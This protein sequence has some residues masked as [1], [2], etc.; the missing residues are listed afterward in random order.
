MHFPGKF[1]HY[2]NII[3]QFMIAFKAVIFFMLQFV[4][5]CLVCYNRNVL[6]PI[7][8]IADDYLLLSFYL[9]KISKFPGLLHGT[10]LI[11]SS[12]AKQVAH[13]CVLIKA[14]GGR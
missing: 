14:I 1:S 11:H 13:F 4:R 10:S 2:S 8:S 7:L 5:D 9:T 12:F 3:I 6:Y